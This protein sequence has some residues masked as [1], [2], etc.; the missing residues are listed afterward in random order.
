MSGINGDRSRFHRERKQQIAR[1]KRNREL[2]RSLALGRKM[3]AATVS[4][5]KAV[6]P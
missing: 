6:S 1:R 3:T 5:T 2:R 4:K